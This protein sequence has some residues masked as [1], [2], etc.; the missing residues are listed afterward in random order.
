MFQIVQPLNEHSKI[1]FFDWNKTHEITFQ[2][3]VLDNKLRGAFKT[4][5]IRYNSE[6]EH[7]LDRP[8]QIFHKIWEIGPLTYIAVILQKR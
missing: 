4:V 1:G 8:K 6:P 3:F 5:K 7:P 2:Y